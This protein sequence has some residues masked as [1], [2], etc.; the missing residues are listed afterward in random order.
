[1]IQVRK[2]C[3]SPT[4]F[5]GRQNV[6]LGS[7]PRRQYGN[8]HQSL[9]RIV[10]GHNIGEVFAGK[11]FPHLV[12]ARFD[13]HLNLNPNLNLILFSPLFT[14]LQSSLLHQTL[15]KFLSNSHQMSSVASLLEQI[16]NI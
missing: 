4:H 7:E 6:F 13:D 5:Y 14:A 15:P 3:S 8:Y 11:N 16:F 10:R 12:T 1:M 2:Q 9:T